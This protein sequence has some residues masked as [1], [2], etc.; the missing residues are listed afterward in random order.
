MMHEPVPQHVAM[1]GGGVTLQCSED[2]TMPSLIRNT[3]KGLVHTTEKSQG[4]NKLDV[5]FESCQSVFCSRS[6]QSIEFL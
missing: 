6:V 1:Q 5:E 2:A 3:C 4:L